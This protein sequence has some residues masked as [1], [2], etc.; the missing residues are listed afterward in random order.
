MSGRTFCRAI[1]QPSGYRHRRIRMQQMSI[2]NAARMSNNRYNATRTCVCNKWRRLWAVKAIE[3][4][5]RNAFLCDENAEWRIDFF[6]YWCVELLR[7]CHSCIQGWWLSLRND[8]DAAAVAAIVRT[9]SCRRD[10][11]NLLESAFRIEYVF[12]PLAAIRLGIF[13]DFDII[14]TLENV[15]SI[16]GGV[17]ESSFIQRKSRNRNHAGG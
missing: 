12:P 13:Y 9:L 17:F 7:S 10:L 15:Y 4:G 16:T 11:C 8:D 3:F 2:L 6:Q 14:D 1:Q 5:H